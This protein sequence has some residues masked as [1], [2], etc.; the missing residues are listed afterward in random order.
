MPDDTPNNPEDW[1]DSLLPLLTQQAEEA[2]LFRDYYGGEHRIANATARFHEIFGRF[3][4]N[5]ADNWCQI[6]VDSSVER[7]SVQG[8]R[9]GG[10]DQPA[11]EEAWD[12]WQANG[13]D[14]GQNQIHTEAIKCGCSFL[15]VDPS[16]NPTRIT[17]EHPYEC[18]VYSDPAT[19]ERLAGIKRWQGNDKHAYCTLY[20]PDRVWKWRSRGRVRTTAGRPTWEPVEES[21]G[22]MPNTLGVVPLIPMENN[23]DMLLGGMSDLEVIIPLQDRVNKLCL[24]LDVGSE[25]HA[26]PQRYAAGWEPA[27]GADGQPIANQTV[28][29]AT[30]RFLAFSD[31]DTKVGSLPPGDPAAY[32]TPIGMYINHIAALSRTPPHYILGQIVNISGDALKAAETGLVAKVMSKQEDFSDSWE[33]AI[34]L[35][36]GKDATDAEV[37]W[38]NPESRTFGQLVDGVIKLR[39]ELALPLEICWEMVGLTPQ[40]IERAKVLIGLPE[41]DFKALDTKNA[42]E[43]TGNR[44]PEQL[45][46]GP[47]TDEDTLTTTNRSRRDARVTK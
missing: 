46:G 14:S 1:R 18:Y 13:L 21:M 12:L 39:S 25:F 24:D 2:K 22:G 41:R 8:F 40:Q 3:F 5:A 31:P 15:L 17:G 43:G 44:V 37:I 19:R 11:D 27:L 16:A 38:R 36:T 23:R 10:V 33:E 34:G 7:L 28:E 4:P 32:V 20:L 45:N 9:F 6:V 47:P 26:A 35:S 42:E 30:S 29:A